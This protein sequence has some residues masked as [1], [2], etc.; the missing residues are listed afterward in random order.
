MKK[1]LILIALMHLVLLNPFRDETAFKADMLVCFK[2]WTLLSETGNNEVTDAGQVFPQRYTHYVEDILQYSLSEGAQA[3]YKGTTP[4]KEV[5]IKTG[6][7]LSKFIY[8]A[9]KRVPYHNLC[10]G[11]M[12]AF[13]SYK[14]ATSV[15]R[16]NEKSVKALTLAGL[17]H[18]IGH[19]GYTNNVCKSVTKNS[20]S[21]GLERPLFCNLIVGADTETCSFKDDP[22]FSKINNYFGLFGSKDAILTA[23]KEVRTIFFKSVVKFKNKDYQA[24]N[25]AD[26]HKLWATTYC[27]SAEIQHA[28]IS[29]SILKKILNYEDAAKDTFI[30]EVVT[31]I[32][33]THMQKTF[34]HFAHS[35]TVF[36]AEKAYLELVHLS[37]LIGI[38]ELN[39]DLRGK[40]AETVNLEFR[41]EKQLFKEVTTLPN[42]YD[43][44]P[45]TLATNQLG[46]GKTVLTEIGH[47]VSATNES[48]FLS[49]VK[50][51][52]DGLQTDL[53]NF[54]RTGTT[55]KAYL[56]ALFGKFKEND[57]E[58][59]ASD[60]GSVKVW[61]VI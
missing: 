40:L 27:S 34:Q 5:T 24:P 6:L 14:I 23:V 25:E 12:V 43:K 2:E 13:N 56:N 59:K 28:I 29:L 58:L 21:S 60:D 4:I 10:H 53:E 18:D 33:M 51:A 50:T 54:I 57:M 22:D 16:L 46:F 30:E 7:L 55:Q 36:K 49:G 9:Y 48:T 1:S 39:E 8:L 45:K 41:Q 42:I 17:L 47:F 20:F 38:G 32:L 31:S 35:V 26:C 15:T 19:S 37:D 61:N 44:N 11:L 52:I 3:V